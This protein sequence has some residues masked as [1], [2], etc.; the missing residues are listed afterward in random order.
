MCAYHNCWRKCSMATTLG[1]LLVS[2]CCQ[3]CARV[4]GSTSHPH[5]PAHPSC[6]KDSPVRMKY[7]E[8]AAC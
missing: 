4:G 5:K 3:C 2:Q 7:T 6:C 1:L 8:R